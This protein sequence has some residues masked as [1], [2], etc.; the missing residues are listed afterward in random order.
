MPKIHYYTQVDSTQVEAQRLLTHF[1]HSC[2]LAQPGALFHVATNHQTQ[3]KGRHT[4]TW[5]DIPNSSSLTTTVVKLPAG[6]L[7]DAPWLTNLAA[8]S[9]IETLSTLAPAL[10][11]QLQLKWP[12]DVLLNGRKLGGILATVLTFPDSLHTYIGVG[13]GVNFTQTSE[14]LPTTEATSLR[15]QGINNFNLEDYQATF[16]STF[17]NYLQQWLT[18]LDATERFQKQYA[19][20]LAGVGETVE[21]THFQPENAPTQTY[22]AI[23]QGVNQHGH[24]LLQTNENTEPIALSA[25]DITFQ[26]KGTQA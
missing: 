26:K 15:V 19:A 5:T 25:A 22:P 14:Q 11:S 4:R 21:V 23:F 13:V 1:T 16:F 2:E 17:E 10:N 18:N 7:A 8:L 6:R 12:N 20:L 24:A 9:V 3:G